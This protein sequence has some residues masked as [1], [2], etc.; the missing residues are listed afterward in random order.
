[1]SSLAQELDYASHVLFLDEN[2]VGVVSAD[3]EDGDAVARERLDEGQQDSSLRK[4]EWAFELQ[5]GPARAGGDIFGNVAGGADDGKFV[6]GAGD[7]D[8]LAG[9]SPG[10]DG[11]VGG[12]AEDG[13]GAGELAEFELGRG[14]HFKVS[15][16]R[17]W[18]VTTH[19]GFVLIATQ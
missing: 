1:M 9:G 17:W 16:S 2:V 6:G 13:V 19:S 14:C 11:C 5:A 10:G 15:M 3:G 4:Q 18:I 8:E 12:E 7:G